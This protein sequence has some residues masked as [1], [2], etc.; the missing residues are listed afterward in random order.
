VGDGLTLLIA[1]AAALVLVP[2]ARR[3]GRATGA[4]D[5]PGGDPLKIH[6]APISVLGGLGVIGACFAALTVSAVRPSPAALAA[7]AL[8]LTAGLVDD[9]RSLPAPVQAVL[10]AAA[11][12]VLMTTVVGVGPFAA[13]GVVA[14]VLACTN[15]VN[16]IDG[17]DGLAAGLAAI[18]CLGL[19]VL[20]SGGERALALSLAGALG[21]FLLWNR[22]PARIFLGNG[23]TYAVGTALAA[24]AISAVERHGWR[25]AL[26][27]AL[28]LGVFAFEL[29][30]TVA[31]RFPSRSFATGDREH[32]YDLAARKL[33]RGQV[34]LRF[35]AVGA[36]AAATGVAV[37]SLPGA[38]AAVVALTACTAAA[39]VAHPLWT[40]GRK[41]EL[42]RGLT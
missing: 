41:R 21:A 20:A 22:P 12:L 10:Q 33:V 11:G 28:C 25:G 24:L 30:F 35:A 15:G 18:A 17:Q 19:A 38:L 36:L 13:L 5:D 26:A 27:A 39:A 4:V 7:V 14:L 34:T 31:R 8:A 9:L 37:V 29:A 16:W 23:G 3:I 2:A 1:F 32:T 42:A 6:A 40:P